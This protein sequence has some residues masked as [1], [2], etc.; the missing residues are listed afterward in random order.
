MIANKNIM[1]ALH[2]STL[3]AELRNHEIGIL[4]G[5]LTL[6]HYKAGEVIDKPDPLT[7]ALLI[8]VDGKIEVSA[9]VDDEPMVMHLKDPGELARI[10]SFVGSSMMKIDA[11][12]VATEDSTVLE[13]ERAKLEALL[14]THH[15]IVYYV[16]RGLVRYAHSLARHKSAETCEM[17]NYFYRLNGRF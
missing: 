12:I 2:H 8:L 6:R 1:K 7:D 11:T 17:S 14:D 16:M 9:M 5:L 3:I 10:I 4:T 15:S 13:L